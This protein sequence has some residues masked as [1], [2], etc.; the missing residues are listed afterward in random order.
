MFSDLDYKIFDLLS[1]FTCLGVLVT[2]TLLDQL[3]NTTF[4]NYWN[5]AY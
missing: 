5:T 1:V 2:R 4:L 3:I